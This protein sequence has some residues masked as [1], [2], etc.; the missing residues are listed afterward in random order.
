MQKYD[1][2]VDFSVFIRENRDGLIKNLAEEMHNAWGW[3]DSVI[4]ISNIDIF[5]SS[6]PARRYVTFKRQPNEPNIMYTYYRFIDYLR[7]EAILRSLPSLSE[8][9]IIEE[10]DDSTSQE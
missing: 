8:E 3:Q 7:A 9:W 5:A 2:S 10:D 1:G 4:Y 6:A